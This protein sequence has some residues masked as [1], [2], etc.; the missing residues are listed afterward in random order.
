MSSI[1]NVGA[2]SIKGNESK[3]SR[4]V[5]KSMKK[6]IIAGSR[7]YND[8]ADFSHWVDLCFEKV[9]KSIEIVSGGALGPDSMGEKYANEH[10]IKLR[11][12]PAQWSLH[13]KRAG[14]IRNKDMGDYADSLIAFWDGKS[15]GTKNMIEYM[16]KLKKKVQ[17]IYL[18]NYL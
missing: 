12:F 5:D 17:V 10:E 18:E 16:R 1:S 9:K 8:Y 13:G 11:I 4:K 3:A 7:D 14:I 6:I 15:R 2:E